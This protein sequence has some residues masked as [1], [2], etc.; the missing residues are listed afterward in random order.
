[1][2]E[3]GEKLLQKVLPQENGS[4]KYAL[5]E[6]R[7]WHPTNFISQKDYVAGLYNKTVNV[8][9]SNKALSKEFIA[10]QLSKINK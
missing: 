8:S 9:K 4:H 5:K 1:M 3:K 10:H 7:F 2:R 6:H